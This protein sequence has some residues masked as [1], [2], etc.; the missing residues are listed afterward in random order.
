VADDSVDDSP[1]RPPSE[2]QSRTSRARHIARRTFVHGSTIAVVIVVVLLVILIVE[3]TRSVKVG[4]IFGYSHVSL[5][6]LV[7][8]SAVLGWLLGIATGILVRR[9]LRT[10]RRGGGPKG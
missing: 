8:F 4:W 2:G 3:N 1:T 7:L 6:F 10:P 9:R 5:V